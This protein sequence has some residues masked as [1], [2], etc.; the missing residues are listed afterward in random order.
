MHLLPRAPYVGTRF[1]LGAD[2]PLPKVPRSVASA[3]AR[4]TERLSRGDVKG[5]R[6]TLRLTTEGRSKRAGLA[7][8]P[9]AG[10]TVRLSDLWTGCVRGTVSC[11]RGGNWNGGFLR[12]WSRDQMGD[13]GAS[14]QCPPAPEMP[15]W[16]FVASV[17][18]AFLPSSRPTSRTAP[19]AQMSALPRIQPDDRGLERSTTRFY[20][21]FQSSADS[22]PRDCLGDQTH[23]GPGACLL[24]D[25]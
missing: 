18:G 6:G 10:H 12:R 14:C 21:R 5:A 11:R 19:R 3:E 22:R 9:L 20:D 8:F 24:L 17:A 1:R 15:V 4:T 16:E 13:R 23:P 2:Q 25:S 7:A